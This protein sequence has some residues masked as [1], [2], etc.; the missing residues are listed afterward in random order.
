MN[1]IAVIKN[2]FRRAPVLISVL[3]GLAWTVSPS[4][5]ADGHI[6]IIF[7]A[8]DR[9]HMEYSLDRRVENLALPET[10]RLE[11]IHEVPGGGQSVLA[12][13]AG[14]L[15]AGTRRLAGLATGSH[16]FIGRR[17]YDQREWVGPG[18]DDW[19]TVTREEDFLFEETVAPVTNDARGRMIYDE[20]F[21]GPPQLAFSQLEI[22]AGRRLTLTG[23][24]GPH[25]GGLVLNGELTLADCADAH[26]VNGQGTGGKLVASRSRLRGNLAGTLEVACTQC[27]LGDAGGVGTFGVA[28]A[29][30]FSLEA[31]IGGFG[32]QARE[33]TVA[34]SD[35]TTGSVSLA[36][37]V[38]VQILNNTFT[39]GLGFTT[40]GPVTLVPRVT[41]N[42]FLGRDGV[43]YNPDLVKIEVSGNFWGTV[44]GPDY[45]ER[46]RRW[47][48]TQGANCSHF[49][50][51]TPFLRDGPV[52]VVAQSP[53][54]H[55][56]TPVWCRGSAVGQNV[57]LDHNDP[58]PLA[59]EGRDLLICFDLRAA[60]EDLTRRFRL[61]AGD[62]EY[63]PHPGG[64]FRVQR[65]YTL[66][67]RAADNQRRTLNFIIPARD[68]VGN[69]FYALLMEHQDGYSLEVASG[70]CTLRPGF[71]RKLR[72]GVIPVDVELIGGT[73]GVEKSAVSEAQ[74]SFIS[75]LISMTPLAASDF[76]F[77]TLPTHVYRGNSYA[78]R[79][80]GSLSRY[81]LFT[82]VALQMQGRLSDYNAKLAADQRLDV[83][84]CLLPGEVMGWNNEGF[85]KGMAGANVIFASALYP[86][87]P[88]H[89]FG[90]FLGLYN[91]REQYSYF[92]SDNFGNR[93]AF[94]HGAIVEGVTGFN[95]GVSFQSQRNVTFGA[96]LRHFP[97][98]ASS[99]SRTYDIMGMDTPMWVAPSTLRGF[100]HGLYNLLGE[101]PPVS[102]GAPVADGDALSVEKT[103]RTKPEKGEKE[104][105]KKDPDDPITANG[106]FPDSHLLLV[107]GLLQ[108]VGADALG[109]G[110]YEVIPSS[111]ML[112]NVQRDSADES[113]GD[114]LALHELRVH[115]WLHDE[116]LQTI[117]IT[118]QGALDGL[119]QIPFENIVYAANGSRRLTLW[120]KAEGRAV[121]E[122]RGDIFATIGTAIHASPA[123]GS[124][125]PRLRLDWS[126]AHED[127]FNPGGPMP[128][129]THAVYYSIDAQSTWT[130]ITGVTTD[131]SLDLASDFLPAAA[132]IAFKVVS[133]DPFVAGEAVLTGFSMGNR[134]PT[135]S[136]LS[137]W[138]GAEGL[139]ASRWTLAAAANDPE[140]GEPAA[141]V[142]QSTRDGVLG[143]D[144]TLDGVALSPGSHTLT[145]TATDSHGATASASLAVEV[146]PTGPLDLFVPADA[147]E[148][149]ITTEPDPVATRVE[150][151]Q[152]GRKNRIGVRFLNQ[153]GDLTGEVHGS[154]FLKIDNDPEFLLASS[155]V[156]DWPAFEGLV[157]AGE[158]FHGGAASYQIRAEITHIGQTDPLPANN[159]RIWH[160]TNLPPVAHG[161]TYWGARGAATTVRLDGFDPDGD[162]LVPFVVAP[163]AEGVL[164]GQGQ[165]RLF[166]P[167]S[168]GVA[169][170]SFTFKLGDG[171]LESA[172]ATNRIVLEEFA[173]T[174]SPVI[175]SPDQIRVRVGRAF[176]H[177]ILAI[178][179]PTGFAVA[180]LPP[181][182]S[183]DSQSGLVSGTPQTAG[184]FALTLTA[185]NAGGTGF[186]AA[187]L[188]VTHD[189]QT[190][191]AA[192]NLSGGNAL[193]TADPDRDNQDNASEYLFGGHPMFPDT[194]AATRMVWEG[195]FPCIE[196]RQREG[197]SGQIGFDYVADGCQYWVEFNDDLTNPAGWRRDQFRLLWVEGAR[198]GNGDGT[199]T[200]RVRFIPPNEMSDR[201]FLRVRATASE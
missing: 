41:G 49:P 143:Q 134:P 46:P 72:V 124:I 19:I 85:Y 136:I 69:L 23:L 73:W 138:P 121:L 108:R 24:A 5:G 54:A 67:N 60:G 153:G 135:V 197:G 142:W 127:A 80:L 35:I 154:L 128:L 165:V 79:F 57:F 186:Q 109:Q 47:L 175:T 33:L 4:Q 123:S 172:T 36:D 198:H 131:T 156:T 182:V 56:P 82:P 12:A 99:S 63:E 25:L 94:R 116:V 112:R 145:V 157:V 1:A 110:L 159:S 160:F 66:V 167:N 75:D 64:P 43:A 89:E 166:R 151:L 97:F 193:A 118:W 137:P 188:R 65:D 161:T 95:P 22:P 133:A 130:P 48:D 29:R 201:G 200:V 179:H 77:R 38:N 139:P 191:A 8:G 119:E 50:K 3:L 170:G 189:Y 10:T 61:Q 132:S 147:L 148:F 183:F 146:K 140:D 158:H 177:Q 181:G 87:A 149:S 113:N 184:T 100:Y 40:G 194:V 195:D 68:V 71:A 120:H 169:E 171:R 90:H 21:D 126:A 20:S 13:G 155:V 168:V 81:G 39:G 91:G 83:M 86:R 115:R 104:T 164:G 74:A 32:A 44:S 199:E 111:V 6:Y 51:D 144:A 59:R 16:R 84:L 55:P 174:P 53:F 106:W 9:I 93:V 52:R 107:S 122:I 31:C 105:K 76:E 150:R 180:G 78:S 196:Y 7:R 96:R 70:Y 30:K 14:K 125:G 190:W 37:S 141:V 28:G 2:P 117:P 45:P 42:S 27:A 17:F 162:P 178:N 187:E 92:T 101:K 88:V 98:S 58:W 34:H 11:L 18:P 15:L 103:N 129:I 114:R 26:F 152:T 173:L 185:S 62:K 102:A 163:P 176:S 192:H